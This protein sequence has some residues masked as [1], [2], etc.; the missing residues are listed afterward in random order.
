[1]LSKRTVAAVLAALLSLLMLTSCQ[2]SELTGKGE[3]TAAS[4]DVTTAPS[5]SNAT[6][7]PMDFTSVDPAKYV[8]L[9]EYRGVAVSV[10]PEVLTDEKFTE[11][12]SALLAENS[13][14][15]EIKDR[16]AVSGD[17]LNINFAGYMNGEQ[18]EN[19]SA[20]NQTI[21]LSDQSGY[22]PGFSD[23]LIGAMPGSEVTLELTFPETYYEDVAGKPVTFI[24]K[25]NYIQ[26]DKITPV[27]DNDF[28]SK[29]TEGKYTTVDAFNTYYRG[30]LEAE[31]LK[32]A[33]DEA[34]TTLWKSIVGAAEVL[35]YPEQQV[36]YY[37]QM[38]KSQYEY[39]AQSYSMTYESVLAYMS[40]T[41][42]S[43]TE[44]AREMT[45]EDLV[46]YSIVKAE[47]FE[48]SD[49]EYNAGA[50]KYAA[51]AGATVAALE[52]YYGKDYIIDCLL[53]D[54]TLGQ[55]FDWADVT[56]S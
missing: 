50:A 47:G 9:G 29:Y 44:S 53:W 54:E 6:A 31:L 40:V 46:F 35:E 19:G 33:E 24:V 20:D 42:E 43:M 11:S 25:V 51:E 39:Y 17:T 55:L 14:Y 13:Y 30:V 45:K 8:R 36:A 15:T 34:H 7:Q 22:I 1:M 52:E 5:G 26:G 32:T 4:G 56:R 41:E 37:M 12:I 27:L 21:T 10:I 23:G 18:F 2:L 3:T 28:V 48:V 49:E 16:A 38:Q